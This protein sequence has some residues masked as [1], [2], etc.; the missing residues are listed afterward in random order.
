VI[1]TARQQHQDP[2]E[3]IA[4][5]QHHRTATVIDRLKL[6]AARSDPALTG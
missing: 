3:L 6:P 1:C 4:P 2:I 5:A